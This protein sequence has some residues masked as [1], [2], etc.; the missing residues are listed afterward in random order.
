MMR[1]SSLSEVKTLAMHN[2]CGE[3]QQSERQFE[4]IFRLFS[5]GVNRRVDRP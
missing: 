1:S 2:G 4:A 3:R 5:A